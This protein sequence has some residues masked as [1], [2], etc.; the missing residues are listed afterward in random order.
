MLCKHMHL[1]THRSNAQIFLCYDMI[2]ICIIEVNRIVIHEH[3]CDTKIILLDYP[4]SAVRPVP[5]DL[6]NIR[7]VPTDSTNS[8]GQTETGMLFKN[9]K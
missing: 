2:L 5:T 6:T 8:N 3:L 9:Q 1:L 7:P 4:D